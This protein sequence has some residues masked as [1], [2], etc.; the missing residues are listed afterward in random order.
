LG[1]EEWSVS[2]SVGRRRNGDFLSFR[3]EMAGGFR[4]PAGGGLYR[5]TRLKINDG[6]HHNN[7]VN[8]AWGGRS[9]VHQL[10]IYT[11]FVT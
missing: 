5:F 4:R 9:G 8:G 10:Y 7:V 11:S 3:Q 6:C 2:V 1:Y